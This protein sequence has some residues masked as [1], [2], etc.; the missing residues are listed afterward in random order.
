MPIFTQKSEA[1]ALQLEKAKAFTK[2]TA[3]T[4]TSATAAAPLFNAGILGKASHRP[5][6]GSQTTVY[7]LTEWGKNFVKALKGPRCRHCGCT[8]MNS[9]SGG[10][11]WVTRNPPVCS[12]PS[13]VRKQARS[14][15]R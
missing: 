9:C 7:W 4:V 12:T 10:C 15:R 11:S 1:I 13:C 5:R 2:E 8:E 3:R 6:G 14:R